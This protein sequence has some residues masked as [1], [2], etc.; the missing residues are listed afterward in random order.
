MTGFLDLPADVLQIIFSYLFC[1]EPSP[2]WLVEYYDPLPLWVGSGT[3]GTSKS[4]STDPI[5]Y[6]EAFRVC[7]RLSIEAIIFAYS[8]NAFI[9]RGRFRAFANLGSLALS[10][11]KNLTV[12]NNVWK[13]DLIT[14]EQLWNVIKYRCIGLE[15]FELNLHSDILFQVVPLLNQLFESKKTETKLPI[16]S[17]DLFVWERHLCFEAPGTDLQRMR[18]LLQGQHSQSSETSLHIDPAIR[19]RRLPLQSD[20]LVLS[21]DVT[22]SAIQA[23]DEYIAISLRGMLV[24]SM[25]ELPQKGHRANG[26]IARYIYRWKE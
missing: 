15:H 10:S 20:H 16:L 25:C 12:I 17:L 6:T 2:F 22:A 19:L 9:L 21:A 26:R 1:H 4:R 13:D 3:P 7:R 18:S 11:I 24:K 8:N 14:E 23:L 5:F